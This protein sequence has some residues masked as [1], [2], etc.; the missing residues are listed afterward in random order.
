M[1][2]KHVFSECYLVN[3]DSVYHGVM[4]RGMCTLRYEMKRLMTL[5]Y[6][7]NHLLTTAAPHGS[8]LPFPT[9]NTGTGLAPV[10]VP[11]R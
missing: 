5:N 6:Q 11:A 8:Q 9:R 2:D 4:R 7:T 3:V 10:Y 1:I